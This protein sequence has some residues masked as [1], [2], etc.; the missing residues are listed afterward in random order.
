M[1]YGS[2]CAGIEAATVAW[3]PLGWKAAFYSEI[4]KSACHVLKYHYPTVPLHGDFTT[5]KGKQYGSVDVLIGG[6]PCQSF[7]IAGKRI[8]LDDAR[9]NLS[10]EFI[11]LGL[12]SDAQ[13]MVFENVPGLLSSAEDGRPAGEDFAIFLSAAT[14]CHYE[15]PKEGWGNA[16][17]ATGRTGRYG[18]SWRVLDAQYFGVPQKRRRL[19]VVGYI[20]D[21][22]RAAAVLLE[23]ESL[24]GDPEPRRKTRQGYPPPP[25]GSVI[26][27]ARMTGFG[28]YEDDDLAST[29]KERDHKDATDLI[30][31]IPI[32]EQAM[33]CTGG[34]TGRGGDGLGNGLGIGQPGDPS[35]TLLT[36]DKHGVFHNG[37]IRQYTPVE[38][39]RLMGFPDNYTLCDGLSD[40]QRARLT[41]NSMA[42]PV[43]RWI[44][45]RIDLAAAIP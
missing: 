22:R 9:G 32:H 16:G 8:G 18:I 30:V 19:F 44:G 42:V 23:P 12:R 5:I 15:P 34:G 37:I 7:S 24:R 41:G 33:R 45:Q 17:I 21:W 6:T 25:A 1:I 38:R 36:N 27:H 13:W 14:G 43:I 4:N 3:H 11:A 20:G 40:S 31:T 26:A 39:E 29:L 10:I 2:V 35:S 28:K